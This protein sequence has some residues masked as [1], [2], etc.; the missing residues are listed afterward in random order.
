MES[1]DKA[2]MFAWRLSDSRIL[3]PTTRTGQ[4]PSRVKFFL[5]LRSVPAILSRVSP[6]NKARGAAANVL[7]QEDGSRV[8]LLAQRE[9]AEGGEVPDAHTQ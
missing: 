8:L 7:A 6:S 1:L 9:I 2:K 4:L 3:D 5:G